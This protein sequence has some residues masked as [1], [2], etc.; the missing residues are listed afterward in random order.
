MKVVGKISLLLLTA[1]GML[2][3]AAEEF[4]RESTTFLSARPA[5]GADSVRRTWNAPQ[6]G[7][8]EKQLPFSELRGVT[9]CGMVRST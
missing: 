5:G 3:L 6:P 4:S 1:L 8:R 2:P 9:F 7:N